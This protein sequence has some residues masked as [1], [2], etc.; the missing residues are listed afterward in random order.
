M[1][2]RSHKRW[3]PSIKAGTIGADPKPQ[4][5]EGVAMPP[6]FDPKPDRSRAGRY[7][8]P[9]GLVGLD[10]LEVGKRA[11]ER[12]GFV[13]EPRA[14]TQASPGGLKGEPFDD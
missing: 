2:H 13:N 3:T 12:R 4:T 10:G 9:A 11:W 5:G 6:V 8:N 1:P 14:R 7:S